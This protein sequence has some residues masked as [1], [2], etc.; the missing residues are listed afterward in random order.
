[1]KKVIRLTENDLKHIIREVLNEQSYSYNLQQ[2]PKGNSFYQQA[3]A[4][5]GPTGFTY[6]AA[7]GGKGPQQQNQNQG[8]PQ[9]GQPQQPQGAANIYNQMKEVHDLAEKYK[10]ATI[11]NYIQGWMNKFQPKQN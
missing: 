5:K 10:L 9:G 3:F 6:Q 11:A 8:Q 4:G 1:M 2:Q 7:F